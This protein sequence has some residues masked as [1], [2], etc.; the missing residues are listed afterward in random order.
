MKVNNKLLKKVAQQYRVLYVEDEENLRNSTV[1][2]FDGLFKEVVVACDGKEALVL[3]NDY[4]DNK[5]VFDIV[6]TD[7][8]MPNMG[9]IELSKKII[10]LNK[11]QK[12]LIV[13]AYNETKYFIELIKIGVSGFM[14]KPLTS[15]QMRDILYDVCIE[16]NDEKNISRF[17]NLGNNYRWDRE[18]KI[19]EEN[20][21][22]VELTLNEVTLLNFFVVNTGQK[23]TDIDIFNCIYY[24]NQEKEFSNNAIKSLLK[25][26]RKKL[27]TGLILTHKNLGY[28]FVRPK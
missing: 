3:Y 16:L 6:I 10:A 2:F 22:E 27:P 4:F 12:V 14:Q 24:D 15:I 28:S 7:I 20:F 9:G 17:V 1:E 25:R 18:L 13:S 19:L 23:F 26:L 5:K 21:L 8:K 11:N